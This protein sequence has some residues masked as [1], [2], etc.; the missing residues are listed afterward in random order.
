MHGENMQKSMQKDPQ[1]GIE[2]RTFLLQGNSATNCATVQPPFQNNWGNFIL[3]GGP[4]G[5]KIRE[6]MINVSRQQ[7]EDFHGPEDYWCLCVAWSHLGTSKSRKASVRIA[8]LRKNFEQDPQGTE[9]PLNGMIVLHCRPPEGVPVAEVGAF[10]TSKKHLTL[11]CLESSC[12]LSGS[13][14]V[15][16]REFAFDLKLQH[17]RGSS[18]LYISVPWGLSCRL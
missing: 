5:L 15:V 13:L 1:P 9:V 8:Y 7:V 2:P 11:C 3:L 18:A 12:H 4:S 10:C 16:I 14:I 6:V 17:I